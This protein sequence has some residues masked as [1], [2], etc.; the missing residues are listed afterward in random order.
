M[1]LGFVS[2]DCLKAQRLSEASLLP[3]VRWCKSQHRLRGFCM[4]GIKQKLFPALITVMSF[5][6]VFSFQRCE[7]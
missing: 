6:S 3:V 4:G 5:L 1:F 2:A 7:L